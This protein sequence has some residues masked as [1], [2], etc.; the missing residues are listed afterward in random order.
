MYIRRCAYI[1][2]FHNIYSC[3]SISEGD[4]FQDP[5]RTPKSVNPQPS[6]SADSTPTDQRTECIILII[7]LVLSFPFHG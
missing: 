6:I 5:L 4:W 2:R 3:P 1:V 7:T